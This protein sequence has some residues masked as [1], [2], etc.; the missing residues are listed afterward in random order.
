MLSRI[1]PGDSTSLPTHQQQQLNMAVW[2]SINYLALATMVQAANGPDEDPPVELRTPAL[3][4]MNER[5]V[6]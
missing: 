1:L 2:N 3:D 6:F 4:C 5:L